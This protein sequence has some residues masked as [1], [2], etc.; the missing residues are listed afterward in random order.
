ML[1]IN[2]DSLLD[3]KYDEEIVI[4][5]CSVKIS[6]IAA[7]DIR[8]RNKGYL[9]SSGIIGKTLYI[10]ESHLPSLRALLIKL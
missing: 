10:D 8:V 5:S 7:E 4:D 3:D 9:F 2:T 6:G 1:L